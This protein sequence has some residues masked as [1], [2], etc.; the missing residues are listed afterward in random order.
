MQSQLFSF[1]STTDDHVGQLL[2]S[3]HWYEPNLLRDMR[4][5]VRRYLAIDVGAFIGSHTIWMAGMCGLRV[6]AIE[7]N[8]AAAA[9]L[10][11]NVEANGLSRFVRIVEAAAGKDAGTGGLILAEGNHGKTKVMLGT[12]PIK[13]LPID[14]LKLTNVALVKIDVEG[15]EMDVLEGARLTIDKWSPLL[16]VESLDLEKLTVWMGAHGYTQFGQYATTPVYGFA[17]KR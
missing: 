10:R 11:A 5:R 15:A 8:P 17:R 3:G 6:V 13:V 2:A 9:H 7:P 14:A 1:P 16:Y 4:R 12:G